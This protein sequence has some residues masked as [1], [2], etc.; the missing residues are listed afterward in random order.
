MKLSWT[1]HGRPTT[2]VEGP[3]RLLRHIVDTVIEGRKWADINNL[4]LPHQYDV[5]F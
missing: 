5:L 3:P 2:C 1:L 4:I